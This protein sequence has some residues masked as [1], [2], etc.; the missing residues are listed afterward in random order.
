MK[1]FFNFFSKV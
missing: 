1:S